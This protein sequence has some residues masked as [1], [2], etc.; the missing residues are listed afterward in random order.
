[1]SRGHDP[2]PNVNPAT[3]PT[4]QL[5]Q[6]APANV[7]TPEASDAQTNPGSRATENPQTQG[8]TGPG[9]GR[10]GMPTPAEAGGQV[11]PGRADDQPQV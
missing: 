6:V 10:P 3:T 4:T 9:Q 1:M 7:P 5:K 11:K 8:A 2:H